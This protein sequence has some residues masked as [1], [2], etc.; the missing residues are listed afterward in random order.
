VLAT[1]PI[2]CVSAAIDLFISMNGVVVEGEA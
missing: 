1:S 2:R